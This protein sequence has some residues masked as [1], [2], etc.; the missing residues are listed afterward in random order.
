MLKRGQVKSLEHLLELVDLMFDN[1]QAFNEEVQTDTRAHRRLHTHTHTCTHT[2]M[3]ARAQV[4]Q[5][6]TLKQQLL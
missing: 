4:K 5:K 3:Y 2:H 1:A 6:Q